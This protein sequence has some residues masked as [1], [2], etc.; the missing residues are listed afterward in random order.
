ME[1]KIQKIDTSEKTAYEMA[2]SANKGYV[3]RPMGLSM[4]LLKGL[5]DLRIHF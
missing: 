3:D 5:V 2:S 1:D 4:R